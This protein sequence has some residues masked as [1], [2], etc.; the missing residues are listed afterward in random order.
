MA[1]VHWALAHGVES[2]GGYLAGGL[3]D[4]L[5]FHEDLKSAGPRVLFPE[6]TG[7]GFDRRLEALAWQNF[8]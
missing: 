5:G 7:W 6:G 4:S 1:A 3:T 2:V 8:S